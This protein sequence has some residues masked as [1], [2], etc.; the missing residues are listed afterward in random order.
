MRVRRFEF[1]DWIAHR[2]KDGCHVLF[3]ADEG[4]LIFSINTEVIV[5]TDSMMADV[6]VSKQEPVASE[7]NPR[8]GPLYFHSAFLPP[9]KIYHCKCDE[10]EYS[11]HTHIL[12]E[13]WL[14][15]GGDSFIPHPYWPKFWVDGWCSGCDSIIMSRVP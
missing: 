15:L 1:G 6:A 14:A 11:N 12:W 2:A 8:S 7:F 3:V 10:T 9:L 13:Q 4:G 5:V